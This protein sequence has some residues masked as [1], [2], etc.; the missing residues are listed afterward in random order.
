MRLFAHKPPVTPIAVPSGEAR[1][2]MWRAMDDYAKAEDPVLRSVCVSTISHS[3]H[4]VV[5]KR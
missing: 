1:E 5:G 3:C 2:C 4:A